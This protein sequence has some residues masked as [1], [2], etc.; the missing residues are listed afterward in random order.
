M[1][2]L[3]MET[4]QK[5]KNKGYACACCDA[6]GFSKHSCGTREFG[7]LCLRQLPYH[8]RTMFVVH[9]DSL[10][11][12]AVLYTWN[13]PNI[14]VICD[15][16]EQQ[17]LLD[18]LILDLGLKL[19]LLEG[20]QSRRCT[21]ISVS[22]ERKESTPQLKEGSADLPKLFCS[23]VHPHKELLNL[24]DCIRCVSQNKRIAMTSVSFKTK[25]DINANQKKKRCVIL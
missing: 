6:K 25:G 10:E 24:R 21:S 13:M 8:K 16:T 3:E 20:T 23:S 17:Q 15:S 7:H 11:P 4:K 5:P 9:A 2:G 22:S 14:D 19:G 1:D 18:G 12:R